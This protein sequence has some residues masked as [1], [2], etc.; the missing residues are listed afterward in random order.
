LCEVAAVWARASVAGKDDAVLSERYST[1]AVEVLQKAVTAGFKDPDY[2]ESHAELQPLRGR[3]DFKEL[4]AGLRP[5]P[6]K[7]K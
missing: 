1:R 2:L 7:M 5:G 3:N 4:L 6:V